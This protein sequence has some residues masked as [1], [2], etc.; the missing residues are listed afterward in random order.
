MNKK[1]LGSVPGC[2]VAAAGFRPDPGW[3][4]K[5]QGPS[6]FGLLRSSS[7]KWRRPA[8]GRRSFRRQRA[9][10]R[11]SLNVWRKPV[12]WHS[13]AGRPIDISILNKK[14]YRRKRAFEFG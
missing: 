5:A 7:Q 10:G 2:C 13:G 8:S 14:G 3:G 11:G 9:S 4:V 12:R 6:L 1:K